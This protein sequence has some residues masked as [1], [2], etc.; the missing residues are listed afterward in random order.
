MNWDWSNYLTGG[1]TRPDAISGLD[2]GFNERL[3]AMFANAPAEIQQQL[4]LMS[5]YRSNERQAQLWEA[6][7]Q[8]YGSPEAARKW[9]A[10][11]GRSKHNSGLAADLS[12]L[13]EAAR[14]WA[15][16]NAAQYGLHFPMAHEPWHIEPIGSRD[17][18]YQGQGYQ[19][20]GIQQNALAPQQQDANALVQQDRPEWRYAANLLDPRTFMTAATNFR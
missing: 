20:Q 19:G 4:R 5:A 7:L 17:G 2:A 6:A 16:E 3:S 13:G 14:Q 18:T 8:K 9:V 1:A 10:P 12:Y 15:H 11:P